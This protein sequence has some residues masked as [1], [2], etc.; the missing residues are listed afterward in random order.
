MKFELFVDQP[1]LE[2]KKGIRVTKDTELSFKSDTA[3]QL[4][5]ELKLD[6]IMTEE[7]SNGVNSY[8]SKSHISISLNEGDILLFDIKRGYYLPGYPKV[9]ISQAIEDISSLAHVELREDA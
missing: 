6:T 5:K 7:G 1:N 8:K 9:S 3:E 4:L 2:L